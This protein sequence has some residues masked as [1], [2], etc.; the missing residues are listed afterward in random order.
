[1]LVD[2]GAVRTRRA[3]PDP[4]SLNLTE[5]LQA[6][7]LAKRNATGASSIS[8][9]LSFPKHEVFGLSSQLQRRQFRSRANIAEGHTRGTTKEFLRYVTMAHGSLAEVET[10]CLVARDLHTSMRQISTDSGTSARPPADAWRIGRTLARMRSRI[11]NN[12]PSKS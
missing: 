5:Q 12:A 1:M 9:D 2:S 4:K 10:M 8:S 6:S 3:G 7:R 11:V